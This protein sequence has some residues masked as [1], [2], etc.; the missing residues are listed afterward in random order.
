[1]GGTKRFR[2]SQTVIPAY[3]QPGS[4]IFSNSP[5][6]EDNLKLCR[7]WYLHRVVRGPTVHAAL[8]KSRGPALFD[9]WVAAAMRSAFTN[10][11]MM[12]VTAD[13]GR[14]APGIPV[15]GSSGRQVISREFP[16]SAA[17]TGVGNRHW[18]RIYPG[19][20]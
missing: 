17:S 18:D 4:R 2:V 20:L 19:R 8:E 6:D 3:F 5:G 9:R 12:R 15:A 7:V 11:H 13:T 14:V 10:K 1:M 16:V